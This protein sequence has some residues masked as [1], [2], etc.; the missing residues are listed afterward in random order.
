[1]ISLLTFEENNESR[2]TDEQIDEILKPGPLSEDE[3]HHIPV[4][5]HPIA[6]CNETPV[7]GTDYHK[8][9]RRFVQC[10]HVER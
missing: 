3:I 1:M 5:S 2:N 10:F 7:K 4:A 9:E 8:D 6:E